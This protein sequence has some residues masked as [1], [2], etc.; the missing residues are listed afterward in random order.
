MGRS[1][2]CGNHLCRHFAR[3]QP[4]LPR[5]RTNVP[6]QPFFVYGIGDAVGVGNRP[7]PQAFPARGTKHA[8]VQMCRFGDDAV[9]GEIAV[10]RVLG[11]NHVLTKQLAIREFVQ[12]LHRVCDASAVAFAVA[13]GR[14]DFDVFGIVPIDRRDLPTFPNLI[15]TFQ[16]IVGQILIFLVKPVHERHPPSWPDR[17]AFRASVQIP[18]L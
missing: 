18:I 8:L 11:P 16:N 13:Q 2:L 4:N 9:G 10:F 3:M 12:R 5:H 1:A 14:A 6:H 15:G 17:P 7:K